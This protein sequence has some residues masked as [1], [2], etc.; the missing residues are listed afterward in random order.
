LSA[1]QLAEFEFGDMKL[2]HVGVK[3]EKEVIRIRISRSGQNDSRPPR[4]EV[5]LT[6]S[7]A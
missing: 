4:F 5:R 6:L 1:K 7:S 3:V 2:F